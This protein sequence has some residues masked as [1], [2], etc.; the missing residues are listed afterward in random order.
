MKMA[1]N[2]TERLRSGSSIGMW[3]SVVTYSSDSEIASNIIQGSLYSEIAS[4]IPEVLP[5]VVFS[6]KDS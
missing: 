1:E 2:M 4:G 3:E 5:P 6:Y